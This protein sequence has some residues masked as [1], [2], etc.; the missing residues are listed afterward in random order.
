MS[1]QTGH[2]RPGPSPTFVAAAVCCLLVVLA[3]YSNFLGNAFHFDDSHVVVGN[4]SIRNLANAG[5]FFT[6]AR[7]TTPLPENQV[8]R[9]LVMLSLAA[10]YFLGH[11]LS[12]R[13]FHLDQLF[14]LVVLGIAL[15]FFYLRVMERA[16]PGPVNMFLALFSATLFCVHPV[17]TDT[18]NVMYVRSEILSTLGIVGGFLVYLGS[19]RLRRLQVH[20]V[21]MAAGALAKTPAV[22]LAPLLFVWEFSAPSKNGP[23]ARGPFS[24]LKTAFGVTAPAF[25]AALLLF[26]LVEKRMPP[27]TMVY[28]GGDRVAY[29]RTQLWVWLD[30][31]RLFVLPTGLSADTDLTLIPV[32]YDPRV[33]AGAC[34]VVA[35]AWVAFRCSRIPKAW[36]VTFGLAW[37][38]IGLL[39][40]SSVIPLTEPMNE[41][42]VFLPFIGLVLSAVWGCRLLL[43]GR[44][45]S[46]V[47]AAV[48]AAILVAMAL[49]VHERNR[50]WLTDESLWAD[51]TAKSPGNG[52]GWMNY[53][54][55][56]MAR[57]QLVK[58][59][60]CYER[61]SLL[62]PNYWTLEINRGIVEDALGNPAAAEPHFTRAIELGP[63]Q[64]DTHYYFARWLLKVGRAPEAVSHLETALRISPGA[65]L[66]GSLL[67]DLRA[68]AG[69]APGAAGL[70]REVLQ[71]DPA[72][73]RARAYSE[74]RIP[75]DCG[76]GAPACRQAG[77]AL[78]QSG[79][80][81]ASALAYRA[82]LAL[83]PAD[84]D[85]LNNLGWTLGKLGLFSQ[86][87]PPLEKALAIRPDLTLARNNLAWVKSRV[88]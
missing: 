62:T 63:T 16:S 74:G 49:G 46:G 21:P 33:L 2:R 9:P 36:P 43:A 7:M 66:A 41:H 25:V 30:Y 28:G 50:V 5:R 69:D 20:L 57:G 75:S 60:E 40:T 15:F 47:V 34:A 37:F 56:L 71:A 76:P 78:G 17:N 68:A 72:N 70:A 13:V 24:R 18:M 6:D 73:S 79:A 48:C 58:A 23:V 35:L 26:W 31:L 83:D 65:A 29:A 8:Y 88:P 44:V 32:W 14:L 61:A 84:A 82:A 85:A 64:P 45:R 39:P 10:D 51:V 42:R 81:V 19:P 55:A 53:G 11:G 67:M 3:A 87:I 80:W 38:A 27:P 4:L 52:R 86:A 1:E 12:T 54:Q 59:R 22:L 77:I